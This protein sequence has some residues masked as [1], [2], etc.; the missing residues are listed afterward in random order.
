MILSTTDMHSEVSGAAIAAP[1]IPATARGEA[2]RSKLIVAAE[3]E[4]G[5]KGFHA[6]SVS[7]ITA[8]AGVGQGTFYLYFHTKEEIFTTLV[9]EIGRAMRKIIRD[10]VAGASDALNAQRRGLEAFLAYT[11]QYPGRYRI[12]QESQF[13]DQAAFR[14]YYEHLARAYAE[15]IEAA[16]ARRQL[17]P[18]T[19][20][21]RAWAIMG[22]GH[23]LGMRHGL[24][25]GA[26]PTRDSIDAAMDLIAK[27]MG[28]R[29]S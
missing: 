16:I 3:Q 5:S 25:E 9:Y 23:F 10:A 29:A 4:F 11:G 26:V 21:P 24:R 17:A 13:V 19:A 2:T 12:V 7:S 15:D 18:G 20:S 6:A 14:D 22:I 27:G 28:P 1:L 8:R